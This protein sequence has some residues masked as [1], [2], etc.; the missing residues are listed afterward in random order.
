MQ[1][2][3]A[4][5]LAVA[6]GAFLGVAWAFMQFAGVVHGRT[7]STVHAVCNSWL[8]GLASAMNHQVQSDCT[9]A[10]TVQAIKPFVLVLAVAVI[11]YGIWLVASSKKRTPAV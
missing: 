7:I 9:A 4:G 8:G 10:N 3:D 5:R 6:V 2:D 1:R 11:S